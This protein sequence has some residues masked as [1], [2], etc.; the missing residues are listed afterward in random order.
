MVFYAK[1]SLSELVDTVRSTSKIKSCAKELR[2]T[3]KNVDFGLENR[4]CDANDL[5]EFWDNFKMPQQFVEFFSQFFN[6]HESRFNFEKDSVEQDKFDTKVLKITCSFQSMYFIMHDGR[7]RTPLHIA[8]GMSVHHVSRSRATIM[9]LNRLGL[10]ISYD[11]VERY[12]VGLATYTARLAENLTPLPSH[13]NPEAFTTVAFDNFDHDTFS[14]SGKEGVHDTVSVVYQEKCSSLNFCKP[15]VTDDFDHSMKTLTD[16]LKCQLNKNFRKL[17]KVI[18]LP[19]DYTASTSENI[20]TPES[21]RRVFDSDDFAWYILRMNINEQ[22]GDLLSIKN[23]EQNI[24]AW[25]AFHSL[26]EN[27]DRPSTRIGHLPVLPFPVTQADVVNTALLNFIEILTQLK[28]KDLPVTCD[29]GVYK[30]ACQVKFDN[31]E[32]MKNLC[33]LLGTFHAEKVTYGCCGKYLEG[34]GVDNVLIETNIFG[35]NT[36]EQML[37]GSHHHRAKKGYFVLGEALT[38]LQLKAFLT[39]ERLAEYQSELEILQNLHD[40]KAEGSVEEA[41][42]LLLMFRQSSQIMKTDFE[43]FIEKRCKESPLLDFLIIS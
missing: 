12:R 42:A 16:L 11:E 10:S 18:R 41:K 39:K 3:M 14:I 7:K 25:A 21:F 43:N 8:T 20:I 27:D 13:F 36:V 6:I 24:P 4:F 38:R 29:E 9:N 1:I 19:N 23:E 22:N 15:D 40:A 35:K 31:Y 33:I 26:F 17:P 34:S 2:K 37:S 30:L 28:Q 5:K 32:V